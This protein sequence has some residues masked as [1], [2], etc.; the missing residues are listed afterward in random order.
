MFWSVPSSVAERSLFWME[1]IFHESMEILGVSWW[2]GQWKF[3][4]WVGDLVTNANY[5][6]TNISLQNGCVC[7]SFLFQG[8]CSVSSNVF[9]HKHSPNKKGHTKKNLRKCANEISSI[10]SRYFKILLRGDGY[11]KCPDSDNS[12]ILGATLGHIG[13]SELSLESLQ[14]YG[15]ACEVFGPCDSKNT[16]P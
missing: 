16:Q 4:G 10:S 12:W 8:T 9:Q 15:C 1:G 13:K 2:P 11:Q 7:K 6:K 14:L 5:H 3:W